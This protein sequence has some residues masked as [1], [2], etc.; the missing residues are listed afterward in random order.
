MQVANNLLDRGF[1]GHLHQASLTAH[2]C[3]MNVMFLMFSLAMSLA[4]GATAL[5][6]RAYGAGNVSEYRMAAQQALRVA[7]IGGF[8][9]AAITALLSRPVAHALIPPDDHDAMTE[10][11]RF[12]L[13]YS[14]GLPAIWV[15]QALAGSMRGVG[16]TKSPMVISGIQ[17]ALHICFNFLLIFPVR[18]VG[19]FTIPGA[20][21]GLAGA[22][23]ALS[24]SAWIASIM[25]VLYASRTRLG[26]VFSL[27]LP[28]REWIVRI[29]RIAIPAAA[30]AVLRVLSLTAFTL[31]LKVVPNG[32]IAIAAMSTG[33]AI[34]SV[35]FMPAFG[36]SMAAGALVGQSLGMKRPDRAEKL[37]WTAA[38][39]AAG[40]TICLCIPIFLLSTA[41]PHLLL[42]GKSE[43]VAQTSMLLRYL[44]FTEVFF[45]YA[46]VMIGAMQG[47]GDTRAPLVITV[48]CLWGVRVPLAIVLALPAHFKLG[49]FLPLPVGLAVGSGGAWMSMS[50]TQAMQGVMAVQLFRRGGWRR[51]TV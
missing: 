46:M 4:T 49:G 27:S 21:L 36:V 48:L 25:Y 42:G 45:S 20:N 35:M 15:V 14:C 13:A 2:G 26:R 30:M 39:H 11:I 24:S 31:V 23:L 5:V 16:D 51:Q 12:V 3:S 19:S 6:S 34:E 32:S 33:F 44:C 18:H 7:I 37:A 50:I 9:V 22:G 40:V 43:M 1:I 8:L 17:I 29:L 47:A 28:T 10:M 41:I 38:H